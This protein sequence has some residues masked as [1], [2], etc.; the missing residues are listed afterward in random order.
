MVICKYTSGPGILIK[1]VDKF[2]GRTWF[3]VQT[4]RWYSFGEHILTA[5]IVFVIR[6]E[7]G[8]GVGARRQG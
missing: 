2:T 6:E 8:A 1:I 3:G 4:I 5:E 7:S